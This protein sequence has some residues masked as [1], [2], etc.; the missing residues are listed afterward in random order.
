M[1]EISN[2]AGYRKKGQKV[3]STFSFLVLFCIISAVVLGFAGMS[4]LIVATVEMF[5]RS[6]DASHHFH[7][8]VRLNVAWVV[9]MLAVYC[10]QKWD[11]LGC[12][13]SLV[14]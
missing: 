4:T 10:L 12:P 6:G 9:S 14:R 8:S 5:G 2:P 7:V 3:K 11:R 1:S 13:A